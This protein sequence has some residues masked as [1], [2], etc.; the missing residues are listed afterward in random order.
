[1]KKDQKGRFL[2]RKTGRMFEG[3]GVWID[4]RGYPYIHAGGRCLGV[5]VFVWE[6]VNGPIPAGMHLHHVDCDKANYTLD[7]LRLVN[8]ADHRKIHA[9]WKKTNGE[10]SHKWCSGCRKLLPLSAFY[11]TKEC[12]PAARCK[13]CA[14]VDAKKWATRNP[15]KRRAIAR[16]C[17]RRMRRAK[18]AQK[19]GTAL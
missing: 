6:R 1:M 15:A 2:R 14:I 3:F 4:A 12:T 13:L 5:H 18:A 19:K 16:K 8:P 17:S 9:G 11:T 7:N 10:W